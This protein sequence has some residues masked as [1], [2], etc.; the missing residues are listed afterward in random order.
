MNWFIFIFISLIFILSP[1]KTGLYSNLSFYSLSILLFSLFVLLIVRLYFKREV[2]VLKNV[3][4]ILI[5]PL[6]YLLPLPIAE[7]PLGA[8]DSVIQWFSFATFFLLLYWSASEPNIQKWLPFVFQFTG[9][10]IAFYSMF[11]YLDLLQ[12]QNAYIA[13][14]LGSIFKYPNTF[15]MIMIVFYFFSLIFLLKRELSFLQKLIY[16]IPLVPYI[17]GFLASYSRGMMLV[18]PIVWV[19][20]L[21]LLRMK[22]QLEYFLLTIVSFG[23]ALFAFSVIGSRGETFLHILLLVGSI[24]LSVVTVY[25]VKYL[26]KRWNAPLE[27]WENR[28]WSQFMLPTIT[29][30]LGLL[31]VLDITNQGLVYKQLPSGLQERI[32]DIDLT[33]GT[34]MERLI[35]TEDAL[36]ISKESPFI[37]HGGEAFRV[38]F[39]KYQQLPYQSNKTHNGF[40]EIVIDTGWIGLILFLAVIF[41]IYYQLFKRYR[42]ESDNS[43]L[44]AVMLS[45]LVLFIHSLLDFNF[46]FGTVWLLILWL[47][48]LGLT[49]QSTYKGRTRNKQKVSKPKNNIALV[50]IY[51]IFTLLVIS[52]SVFSYR[53]MQADRLVTE[54][55]QFTG[56]HEQEQLLEKAVSLN[57]Y[58]ISYWM[59]VSNVY[60][61]L[62]K[63]DST[64]KGKIEEV[65]AQTTEV[66]PNN[67]EVLKKAGDFAEKLGN[68]Q[69]AVT[70]FSRGLEV[71][72]F[73]TS[74]YARTIKAKVLLAENTKD[75]SEVSELLN[76]AL[77]DYQNNLQAYE[78]FKE[79]LLKDHDDFNSR[80]FTVSNISHEYAGLAYYLLEDYSQVIA[81][82][83][84]L[85]SEPSEQL[86]ALIVLSYEK[87]GKS[88]EAI[89]IREGYNG[90][91]STIIE[92]Y[93]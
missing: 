52:C 35:F 16:V 71:D 72:K 48:V 62:Y 30:L 38:I 18:F 53:F 5:I 75:V 79:K 54:A 22:M 23:Y 33:S 42:K 86:L 3:I 27:K 10:W 77:Q 46:S 44:L 25:L 28:R 91:L 69:E 19:I 55:K 39:K 7:N 63:S 13:G 89:E 43:T 51:S 64:Y 88:N 4:F 80:N 56:L 6:I 34:A 1:Y 59:T 31:M 78:S 61:Q 41:Y 8:W 85:E 90:D 93:R 11:I 81:I 84:Q 73:N 70:Y 49:T 57:P 24:L 74:L 15:A 82:M 29:V 87:L 9:V 37:G 17:I 65:I 36:R 83:N 47:I 32:K 12:L 40:A 68:E 21:L 50:G 26:L 20:G 14:R 76:S 60:L 45:T 92:K 66:E 2:Y 58:N 67:S